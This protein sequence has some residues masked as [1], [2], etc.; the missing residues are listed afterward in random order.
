MRKILPLLLLICSF[1]ITRADEGMW[2]LNMLKHL[3]IEQKGSNLTPEQIYSINQSSVKDAV[4]GLGESNDPLRFF[5]TAELVSDKGLMLTNYH[6]G[7]DMIQEIS[8]VDNNY[9]D[10]GF[11]AQNHAEE[12]YAED[13]TATKVSQIIDVSEKIMPLYDIP[14]L[15]WKEIQDTIAQTQKLIANSVSDTSS[16]HGKVYPF[17]NKNQYILF[18]YDTFEDIRIVGAPPRDIGKFGGDTDNWMWPRHTGDFCVLRIYADSTNKATPYSSNNKPY[19]P[20]HSLPISLKG[21]EEGDFSMVMGF[22]GTTNRYKTSFGTNNLLQYNNPSVITIGNQVL[23]IYDFYMNQSDSLRIKYTAKHDQISNY[24]KYAI[25]QNKGIQD[26]NVITKK[27]DYEKEL[28]EWILDDSTRK[29]AYGDALTN[30]QQYYE[31]T[32]D[33]TYT[34]NFMN[35]GFLNNVEFIV[36]A[37][38]WFEFMHIIQM[39]DPVETALIKKKMKNR[40]EEFFDGYDTRV[41]RSMFIGMMQLYNQQIHPSLHPQ[42]MIDATTGLFKPGY[43]KYAQKLFDKS[44]FVDKEK[45]L[46]FIEN[47]ELKTFQK[48]PA[49]Q[50]TQQTLEIYFTLKEYLNTDFYEQNSKTYMEAILAHNPD[51]LFYPDANSTIRYTYGYIQSYNPK[52]AVTYNYYTTIDGIFEKKDPNNREFHVPQ[53]LSELYNTKNYGAYANEYGELP[54]CFIST[55]DITGGNSGSPV[56]NADGELIGIA[57]DGNWESMSGDIIFEP[58]YQRCISVDIRYVLFIIDK[59]AG[60]S[61]VLDEMNIIEE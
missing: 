43:V 17:F 60:A 51:S 53:K 23:E 39:N 50:V 2:L 55:N 30:L 12:I 24:W 35:I 25:G 38:E 61:Y 21:Y 9:I 58:Q 41:D 37:Y 34:W 10:N 14:D 29:Q 47:P 54:I 57:F 6:C 3:N 19:T 11:W 18:V 45:M 7:F 5:C 15:S 8:S 33:V 42:Y 27:M 46:E 52:D 1:H 56:M 40:I 28:I 32:G 31:K 4:I 48:D 44:I 20:K 59:F 16:L 49:I 22:P 26:L 36:F 13:V